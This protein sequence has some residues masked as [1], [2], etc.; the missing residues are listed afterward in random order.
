MSEDMTVHLGWLIAIMAASGVLLLIVLSMRIA[1]YARERRMES[2]RR[3]AAEALQAAAEDANRSK[4]LFLATL[5]HELRGPLSAVIGWAD[6][7]RASLQDPE[8][9]RRCL[10]IVLRNARQ[11]ARIIDDLLDASSIVAGKFAVELQP[12]ALAGVVNEAMESCRPAAQE[13]GV[14]I[15]CRLEAGPVIRADRKRM[16][17]VLHNLIGNAIKFTPSGGWIRVSLESLEG[18]ARIVVADSGLG[19]DKEALEHIFERFWQAGERSSNGYAGLGLGLPIVSHIVALHGGKIA[20]QSAGRGRGSTFTVELPLIAQPEGVRAPA[21]AA[22]E[23][24]PSLGGL[25]VLAVDDDRDTRAW[26]E[27]LLGRHGAQTWSASSAGEAASLCARVAPHLLVS[28]IAMPEH[29]GCELIRAVRA[30]PGGDHIGA[31]ALSAQT[32]DEDRRRALEAGF[33]AFLPKPCDGITLVRAL[34]RLAESRAQIHPE[35][36]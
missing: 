35:A 4:D 30:S 19:I 6:V 12:V 10:E 23:D 3:K 13:K 11:E 16:L 28:D 15:T 1:F 22:A 9:A 24:R 17:Q 29:D 26:L 25:A 27:R 31:L 21:P 7:A 34:Q 8:E 2:E 32:S 33:D 18:R 14:L 20:A 5:S 36:R